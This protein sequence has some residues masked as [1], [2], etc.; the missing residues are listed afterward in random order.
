MSRLGREFFARSTLRVA[1]DLLG[2]LLV[3]ELDGQR[4]AGRVVEAE[5]Y[6]GW[7]DMASH[8]HRGKTPRNAVMFG[9]VGISYVYF[10]YGRYWLLNVVAKP[11][12]ADY[13]A[14]VL[15]RALEPVEGLH[16]ISEHRAGRPAREWTSGPGR[17]TMALGI[18][19]ALNGLDLTAAGSPLTFEAGQPARGETIRSGP[20]VGL[21]VPE[22]WRS[23][24]WR[25]WIDGNP[26]VSR[27]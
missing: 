19:G 6:T 18:D 11:P 12:G 4:L 14:A 25:F 1:R 21:N 2:C 23:K 16:V 27:G 20:R 17:L 7:G 8:G 9:P 13:P 10:I 24:P 15:L 5:A 26:H 3:R 22:P